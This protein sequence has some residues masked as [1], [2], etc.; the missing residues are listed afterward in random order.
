[1][2]K[3]ELFIVDNAD[4]EWKVRKYLSEWCEIAKSFD[5]ATGYFEI[6]ALLTLGAKWQK[7]DEIRILMGAVASRRTQQAFNLFLAKIKTKLDQSIEKEKEKNDFLE[8]VPAIVNA[9]EQ[10]KIKCKFYKKKKFHAK[11]YITH[12]K[13]DVVGSSALVGSSNFT[14]PGLTENL[15]LNIQ[16]RREVE[17]LQQ[18]FEKHWNDAE[19]ITHEIIKTVERHTKEYTP[20]EVYMKSLYEYFKGHEMTESEWERS[21]SKIYQV[22]DQYQKEGYHALIKIASRYNGAFLCDGVGLGKT[23]VGLMLIERLVMRENKRVVLLVPYA[24]RKPVWEAKIRKYIPEILSGFI[25]FRIINHTD[26]TRRASRDVDW[27]ELMENI[28][29]QAEVIIIDEAH[30]FRNLPTNRYKKLFN[31]AENKQMYLL[32][33]TPINNSLLDLLHQIEIFTRHRRD[34]FGEAPLGI[35]NLRG[36][37]LGLHNK[38]QEQL[39]IS[40]SITGVNVDD[41]EA[42]DFLSMDDLFNTIVV[43]RSRSY[44][45]ESQIKSGESEVLF[46]NRKDPIVIDYSLERTYGRLLDILKEAFNKEKPL[47]TLA[48]YYPLAYYIGPDPTIDPMTEG[49][50]KQ[51]VG[52][53]RT[54]LLKRFESSRIAF[55]YS[56]EDLLMKL[57]AFVHKYNEKLA[58]R[59]EAVN[60][61]VLE[62]IKNHLKKRGRIEEEDLDEDYFPEELLEKVPELDKK[63]YN[64]SEI[65]SETML[66]MTQLIKFLREL[67]RLET[68]EDDKIEQLVFTLKNNE[69]LKNYKVLIFSEYLATAQYV[70]EEL[71]SRGF[72]QV[73]EIDSSTKKDRGEI[74]KCF[75]P[76]YNDSSSSEFRDKEEEEIRI[77]VS[78]DILSEGLNLQDA[79]LLINYDLHWNP[80]RLMQ[81]IGRIDR[82]LDINIEEQM[83]KDHPELNK[84]RGIVQYWNFLPPDDLNDILSLYEKVT[85]KTLVISKM[86]GIQG[87]KLL[88]P[89]DDYEA[90]KDFNEGY[91]GTT[92]IMEKMRLEYQE[93]LKENPM[94]L[95]ELIQF[96]TK[97][98]SGKDHI[99]PDTKAV[100]FC[101][102]L[103]ARDVT[104]EQW[105]EDA[106]SSKWYLYDLES[107]EIFT[108]PAKIIKFIRCNKNTPR[109]TEIKKTRLINIRKK[110]DNYIKNTYLKSVQAPIGVKPILKAWMELS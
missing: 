43:Q 80:V 1:M 50:Q 24:A 90:L 3:P 91:E 81:R 104:T 105:T 36:H 64:I 87:K 48:I 65:I 25:P 77:L 73:Y 88:R 108:E 109:K 7:L 96:P 106:A 6:G 84:I 71:K 60:K 12:S 107:E 67:M 53:I 17:L 94:I 78:T 86:F 69:L 11:A 47:L 99:K 20:F 35:H 70:Y 44:V 41:K 54:L 93:L 51:V 4:S 63:E 59:W 55:Q 21:E 26:L 100:F 76:Y 74:I 79:S 75:S 31:I 82:R 85:S 37:F 30:H 34:Y 18:W 38:L 56:C 68:Q 42:R 61:A 58:K 19:D 27:P 14:Y 83:I 92:T 5:I 46:P 89:E 101:Y 8:G 33:A 97:V 110:M 23:F 32:T 39:S 45:K 102:L 52:L 57:L 29:N 49:R 13:F 62:Y 10:Q 22:L 2:T 66:D 9:L 16:I 103:P 95:D 98:F 28:K 40:S 72:T 15:E